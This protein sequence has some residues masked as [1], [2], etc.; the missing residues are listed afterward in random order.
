MVIQLGQVITGIKTMAPELLQ[1]D[2]TMKKLLSVILAL[3]LVFGL[4]VVPAFADETTAPTSSTTATH[5][6]ITSVTV[7]GT[8]AYYQYDNN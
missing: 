6:G 5:P 3:V 4:A 1:E 8:T 2:I 7:E